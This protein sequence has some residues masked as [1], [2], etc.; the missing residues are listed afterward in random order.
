MHAAFGA[1]MKYNISAN[2]IRVIK[3][4]YDKAASAL[5]FKGSIG[6]RFRTTVGIR[7]GYLLSPTLFNMFSMRIMTDASEDHEGTVSIGGRIITNLCFADDIDGL[8]GEVE[9]LAKLAERLNKSLQST[10][11]I[12]VPRRPSNTEIKVRRQKLE[13]VTNFK[14]LGSVII[15]EGS[16]PEIF[17]RTGQDRRQQH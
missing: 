1:T 8:A 4:V 2:F 13:T 7:K 17:S 12:S 6:N 16:K 15:D 11:W 3:H 5:L 9:V 10:A 14:Y